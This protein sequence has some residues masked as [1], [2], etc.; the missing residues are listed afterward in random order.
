[1][2]F[3]ALGPPDSLKKAG[4]LRQVDVPPSFDLD[5]LAALPRNGYFLA[6][7]ENRIARF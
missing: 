3:S 4:F 2:K 7:E 1:M 6:G 5:L